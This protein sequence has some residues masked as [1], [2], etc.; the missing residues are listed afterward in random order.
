MS[1]IEQD[2]ATGALTSYAPIYLWNQNYLATGPESY[3]ELK[4]ANL[5]PAWEDFS[6][7]SVP[8]VIIV[9]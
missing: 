7:P 5:T 3:E 6:I 9:K 2:I 4:T 1:V 8:P